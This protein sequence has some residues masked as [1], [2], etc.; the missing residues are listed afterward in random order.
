MFTGLTYQRLARL[1]VGK[2][3]NEIAGY[4]A[5]DKLDPNRNQSENVR[6]GG[7]V[8]ELHF[9]PIAIAAGVRRNHAL[10]ER[11]PDPRH[12]LTDSILRN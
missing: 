3:R 1:R 9:V 6:H 10:N 8:G 2:I 4:I 11:R 5:A 12:N 7:G